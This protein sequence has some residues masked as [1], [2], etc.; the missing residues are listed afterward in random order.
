MALMRSAVAVLYFLCASTLLAQVDA[1]IVGPALSKPGD[2]VVLSSEGSTGDN[3]K[4][5]VDERLTGRSITFEDK[6]VFATADVGNYRFV[7]VVADKTAAIDY[8]TIQVRIGSPTTPDPVDPVDPIPDPAPDTPVKAIRE[9]SAQAARTLADPATAQSLAIAL[10]AASGSTI[11]DYRTAISKAVEG[12]LLA[13]TGVSRTK[14]WA[15]AWRRPL[16]AVIDGSTIE[17]YR[18]SIAAAAD[19]LDDSRVANALQ[20]K[21]TITIYWSTGCEPC[22]TWL[23]VEKPKYLASGW[24]VQEVQVASG[25]VPRFEIRQGGKM[26]EHVGYMSVS[27]FRGLIDEL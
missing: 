7:L 3:L 8:E 6:L 4:W 19:G 22:K 1:V 10:R 9:A 11:D 17:S 5:I 24:D 21:S 12:A 23:R 27:T 18:A 15:T 13:R 25:F 2:L 20:S 14:D 26:V 16:D